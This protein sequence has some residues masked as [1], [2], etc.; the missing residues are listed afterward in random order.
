RGWGNIVIRGCGNKGNIKGYQHVGGILGRVINDDDDSKV[1]V[2]VD[3]CYH[4][5]SVTADGYSGLLCGYMKNHGVVSKCWS[6]G[7][8]KQSGS[9]RV[10]SMNNP[11]GE[12]EYFVGYETKLTIDSCYDY[13]STVDWFDLA[14]EKQTQKGVMR[15]GATTVL[16]NDK[17]N[18]FSNE[19]DLQVMELKYT[20]TFNNTNYQALYIPFELDYEDWC[21]D[22]DVYDIILFHE[23]DR[24]DD[25]KIDE[26]A[27]E[28]KR[29]T[30]GHTQANCPYIIKA[31][32]TGEKTFVKN[33]AKLYAAKSDTIDCSTTKSKYYFIGTYEKIK[34]M[35]T[36]GYYA[37]S[38]G[39]LCPAK[40]DAAELGAYRWYLIKEQRDGS[41]SNAPQIRVFVS[42]EDEGATGIDSYSTMDFS[43]S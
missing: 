37:M 35:H 17:D 34:N 26:Y 5:G 13:H 8:L 12:A 24:N 14:V 4:E 20:R 32:A 36:A 9:N 25:G 31:K 11:S 18:S 19:R 16:L 38:S 10:Y 33:N 22:F 23:Y 39:M 6:S 42:G 3:S 28:A 2:A 1:Q 30:N 21:D 40:S 41:S 43:N 7:S 27:L 29:V 15:Y